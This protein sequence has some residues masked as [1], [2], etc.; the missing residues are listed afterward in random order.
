LIIENKVFILLLL[1][2]VLS[3]KNIFFVQIHI[4]AKEK[5]N[6]NFFFVQGDSKVNEGIHIHYFSH[7]FHMMDQ[8]QSRGI[9]P[10]L[11]V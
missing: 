2:G 6:I 8:K 1:D 4:V 11:R 5:V 3:T 9:L 10:M 7:S